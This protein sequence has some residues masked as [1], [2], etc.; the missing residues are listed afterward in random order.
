MNRPS[1]MRQ[2]GF[3]L[4]LFVLVISALAF[5]L[6]LGYSVLLTKTA[7]NQLATKQKAY[8]AQ[9]HKQVE[10]VWNKHA[11]DLDKQGL[12]NVLTVEDVVA[13]GGLEKR[14]GVNFAMSKVMV[15][16]DGV[17]Y[18]NFVAYLPTDYDNENPPNVNLFKE[19]GAFEPC[20]TPGT[21]S[22]LPREFVVYS[23]QDLERRFVR[24]TQSRLMRVAQKAQAYIKARRMSDP[25]QNISVNYF[26]MPLGACK[27]L[28]HDL[29]C[30]PT[31][32]P[33]AVQGPSGYT[34][35]QMALG[36]S[37]ATEDLFT[38][39]GQPIEASN[40]QDSETLLPP[41]TMSFRAPKPD[42]TYFTIK[43]IQEL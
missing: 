36:L 16:S 24:E 10:G 18:R 8:L 15:T 38:A 20:T 39:W 43:A 22:C 9:V 29:G 17:A 40:V 37:I 42:G 19:T 5:S 11:F 12:G 41:F 32:Q 28:E 3:G 25:E 30:A 35:S 2:Q 34:L 31:Y 21:P 33:L 26:Y 27:V 14:Y 4:F 1:L 6:V 13:A 23:S 7:T